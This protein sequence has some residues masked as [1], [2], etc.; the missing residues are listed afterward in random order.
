MQQ[1]PKRS[2]Q[3][4]GII[5]AIILGI[6]G[7]PLLLRSRIQHEIPPAPITHATQTLVILSCHS[8]AAGEA[9]ASG[10]E[11]W[12]LQ[13]YG[14]PVHVDLR[15][16]AGMNELIRMLEAQYTQS[17]RLYWEGTLGRPWSHEVEVALRESTQQNSDIRE[18]F[19]ASPVSAGADIV[20]GGGLHEATLLTQLGYL[21]P[22]QL[23][24]THPEWFSESILPAR[25]A[26]TLL[27]DP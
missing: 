24:Q 18:I 26:G 20:F 3:S 2:K 13:H 8:L 14:Q 5:L 21:S 17:F 4:I 23:P 9:F 15:S 6:V 25:W 19:L 16:I 11:H 12:Y 7:L 22:S 27:Q 1:P 10:F